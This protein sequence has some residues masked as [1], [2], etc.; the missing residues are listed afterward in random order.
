M[1]RTHGAKE[2]RRFL[3]EIQKLGFRV[4]QLHNKYK[5]TPPRH[6]GTRVYFTHGTPKAIKPLCA[7]FKKHYGVELDWQ[8]FI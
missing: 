8:D 7:D 6:L 4:E 3:S 2:I 5:I 1:A